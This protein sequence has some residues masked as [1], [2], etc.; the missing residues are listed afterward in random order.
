MSSAVPLLP[1]L[2]RH[3]GPA[4][5]AAPA[6]RGNRPR[7]GPTAALLTVVPPADP[8][9]AVHPAGVAAKGGDRP[10]HL[11]DRQTAPSLRDLERDRTGTGPGPSPVP[12]QTASTHHWVV[13]D[14]VVAAAEGEEATTAP[15]HDAAARPVGATGNVTDRHGRRH[16]GRR[17]ARKPARFPWQRPRSRRGLRGGAAPVPCGVR[18][19]GFLPVLHFLPRVQG[20][21]KCKTFLFAGSCQEI[22]PNAQPKCPPVQLRA[23]SSHPVA[24]CLGEESSPHLAIISFQGVIGIDKV[25]LSLLFYRRNKP[26]SLHLHPFWILR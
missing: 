19:V 17:C 10:P 21:Q 24:G 6:A 23:L 1:S 8:A 7:P 3:L 4:R 25:P 14:D 2:P 15:G 13:E 20:F 16:L 11:R 9:H 5:A 26:S 22:P 18:G 12:S